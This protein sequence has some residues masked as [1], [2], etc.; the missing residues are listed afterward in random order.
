MG[1]TTSERNNNI[2]VT[3]AHKYEK[4]NKVT[5]FFDMTVNGVSIYGCRFLT[6][7]KGDFVAFPQTKGGDKYYNVAWVKLTDDDVKNIETQIKTM[8]E[9]Q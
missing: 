8:L 9:I 2:T 3:K 4:D 1:F 7:S 6:G 5:M